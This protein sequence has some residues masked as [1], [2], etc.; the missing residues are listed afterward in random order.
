MPC[1]KLCTTK[2][3]NTHALNTANI[4]TVECCDISGQYRAF[5][6]GTY[7]YTVYSQ[8]HITFIFTGFT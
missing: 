7:N 3:S 1:M 2:G 6:R 4:M 8:S 5:A